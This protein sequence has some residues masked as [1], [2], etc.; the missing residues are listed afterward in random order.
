MKL[1]PSVGDFRHHQEGKIYQGWIRS[2]ETGEGSFGP[3]LLWLLQGPEIEEDTRLLT[4]TNLS[5]RS[6]LGKWIRKLY[7]DYAF[8][9]ELDL[10]LLI[11]MPVAVTFEHYQQDDGTWSEKGEIVAKGDLEPRDYSD[12]A[13]F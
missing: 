12:E 1:K 6:K 9:E 10:D 3:Y 7:P 13:P 2:Y 11:G 4:S 8:S 5:E